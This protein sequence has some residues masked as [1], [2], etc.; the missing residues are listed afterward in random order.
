MKKT[1]ILSKIYLLLV[2]LFMYA[3]IFVL[4]V[5]SFNTTKSHSRMSGFTLDWYIKLFH[6]ELIL[7]SLLNTIIVAATAT[8]CATILGTAAAVG[9]NSM[10]KITRTAVLDVTN[11][12]VI[13]PEIVTGVSLMLLF[14]FFAARMNMNF[15]FKTLIMA[16]ITFDVPYVILNIMPRFSQMNPNIYEAAQDLGCSPS[17]AFFKVILPEILPGIISG[18]MMAFALSLDDFVVSYFTNGSSAQTLPITIYSMTRRKVSPEINAL[19][20]IIFLIV[21]IVLITK[22][23]IAIKQDAN[24]R[25]GL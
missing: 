23:V 14:S 13:S 5:F 8:L 3:P 19:S 16:H 18:M 15:G 7:R 9:I 4:I 2:M 11:V 6:N 10:K 22:N 20:T 12:P 25:V 21:I 17:K 24:R 1:P